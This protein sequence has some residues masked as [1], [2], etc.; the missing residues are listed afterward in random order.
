MK[1]NLLFMGLL[2][3]AVM[4]VKAQPYQR[5]LDDG[6]VKWSFIRDVIDHGPGSV[7]MAAYGDTLINGFL[8]KKLFID[9]FDD[10]LVDEDNINWKNYI[11]PLSYLSEHSYI[12]E[13]EDASQLFIYSTFWNKEYLISDLNLQ[14]GESF[15]TYGGTT[16][17]VDSVYIKDGLKHVRLAC[18]EWGSVPV[19]FM[20]GVGPSAWYALEMQFTSDVLLLNCFQNQTFFYKNEFLDYGGSCPCGYNTPEND[21]KTVIHQACNLQVKNE[22][23]EIHFSL[24]GNRLISIYDI[25]GRLH[26]EQKFSSGTSAIIPVASFPKGMYLLKITDWDKKQV[27]IHKFIL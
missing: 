10:H 3:L 8:Y 11:P 25:G 7:E 12:R 1:K 14:V 21:I 9:Y 27:D 6:I 15:L 26:S 20:E 19:I 5:C 4:F 17:T 13:S 18:Y 24:Q 23:I 16:L 2:L 22:N